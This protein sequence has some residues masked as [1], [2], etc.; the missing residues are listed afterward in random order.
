MEQIL[1]N[2]QQTASWFYENN[3]ERKGGISEPELVKLIKAGVI[4]HGTAVW[5]KGFPDWMCIE[6]TELRQYLDNIAPPPLSGIHVNN[7]VVWVLA[8]APVI[9]LCL[10]YFVAGVMYGNSYQAESAAANGNFW[11]ITLILNIALCFWDE[12][13]L[14]KAGIKT[15]SFKGLTWLVP[16]YLYKRAQALK[17]NLAYFI[18]WVVCFCLMFV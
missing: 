5:E 3:G 16:V 4:S 12:K 8:F 6:N 9:G 1:V 18:V 2:E 11:F 13:R 14:E 15:E 10:E 7:S 17:Q